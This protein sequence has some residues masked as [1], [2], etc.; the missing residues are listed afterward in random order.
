MTNFQ[1]QYFYGDY[2][3]GTVLSFEQVGGVAVNQ[4]DWTAA[5][6]SGL[7]FDLTSFGTDGQGEPYIVDRDGLVYAVQPPW[8]NY[9][10]SG[11]GSGTPFVLS[12][13]GPW[14]W[15]DMRT[16]TWQTVTAYRV[17]RA[18]IADGVFHAGE[19]FQCAF[20]GPTNAW[21]S[22]DVLNPLPGRWF[23]YLV[24]AFDAVGAQ[25]GPGGSPPR[26]LGMLACP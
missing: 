13:G 3:A 21:A 11:T 16:A 23:A 14:T 20:T 9:E 26:S 6:G 10:T 25:T 7:A 22:G 15:E 18:D 1:R 5:L 24:T 12:K 19:L 17:Y 8:P 4:Q 2:C